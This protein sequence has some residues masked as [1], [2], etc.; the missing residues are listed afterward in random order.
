[1]PTF[2]LTVYD[3]ETYRYKRKTKRA[4]SGGLVE[5]EDVIERPHLSILGAATPAIF[6]VLAHLDVLS[7]LLPRFAVVM[8]EGKPARRPFFE[9]AP[10]T[11]ARRAAL[12][13]SLGRL[14][15]WAQAD[16]PVLFGAGTLA[17]LDGF[18][19]DLERDV[20]EVNETGRAMLQR[21]TPMAVKLA[22]LAAAGMPDAPESSALVVRLE[23]AEAAVV[24]AT[25]WRG[26][27]LAFAE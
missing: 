7:G 26:Y 21:L 17:R 13:A 8:P 18:A 25:R 27:A 6:E 5:D 19:A 11:E 23:D 15:A 24:V 3:G 9:V 12:V 16:R 10:G 20:A 22:M 14:A 4:K 1:M 2:L